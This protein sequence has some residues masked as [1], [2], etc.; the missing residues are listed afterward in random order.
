[1][2]AAGCARKGTS[3]CCCTVMWRNPTRGEI[4]LVVLGAVTLLV[5]FLVLTGLYASCRG[6]RSLPR[7]V[8]RVS[9]WMAE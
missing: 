8:E 6:K 5:A 1:V 3:T 4:P 7:A 9:H 2:G